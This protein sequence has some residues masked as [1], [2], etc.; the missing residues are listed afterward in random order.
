[1]GETTNT[2]I[3]TSVTT[4]ASKEYLTLTSEE[5]TALGKLYDIDDEMMN[6][7]FGEAG[8]A[9]ADMADICEREFD[10]L[11]V[12]SDNVNKELDS[13]SENFGNLDTDR[14]GSIEIGTS[15]G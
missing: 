5:V 6:F 15:E 3:N 10:N 9:F 13:V 8:E 7:W 1:M 14:S 4:T 2:I 12:F 11:T